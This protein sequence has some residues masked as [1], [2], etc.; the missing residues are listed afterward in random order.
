MQVTKLPPNYL[1]KVSLTKQSRQLRVAIHNM[2]S[3][4]RSMDTHSSHGQRIVAAAAERNKEPI[5]EVLKKYLRKPAAAAEAK[6]I[7]EI[8]SGT[9]QHAAYF[10]QSFPDLTW[11]PTEATVESFGS[12]TAW[13]EGL[14]NIAQSPL[15]LDASSPTDQWPVAPE[16]CVAVVC[17]NM[18]HISPWE[19]TQGLLAGSG[20]VLGSGGQLFIYG[21]FFVDGKPTTESNAAFDRSLRAHNSSW[22]LR[23]VADVD[24]C[25]AKA[26]LVRNEMLFMPANNFTLIYSKN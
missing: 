26:G 6:T 3:E 19:A 17:V 16:S 1:P 24:A 9:G 8:A 13:A 20:R 25:A 18:T 14:S 7:L 5:L 2:A 22:G 21:P 10:S 15:L 23:D 12:I 11:Q 4:N